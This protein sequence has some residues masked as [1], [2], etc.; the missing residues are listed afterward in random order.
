[1]EQPAGS[2]LAE[3]HFEPL[4]ALLQAYKA[5]LKPL[6]MLEERW[7]K[8][9]DP[10]VEARQLEIYQRLIEAAQ[11]LDQ[12]IKQTSSL[13]TEPQRE[14]TET[15]KETHIKEGKKEENLGN[16]NQES[17]EEGSLSRGIEIQDIMEPKLI[18]NTS[19][20]EVDENWGNKL[21]EAVKTTHGEQGSETTKPP[22]EEID[23]DQ[24]TLEL[25]IRS[26]YGGDESKTSLESKAKTLKTLPSYLGEYEAKSEVR[27]LP[28][29]QMPS[30]KDLD[31]TNL[32]ALM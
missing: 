27:K 30:P 25:E 28:T 1:M 18:S 15:R 23:F 16:K 14:T 3:K 8:Y 17:R 2:V 11:A 20:P 26:E 13:H 22:I 21:W 32:S 7:R 29:L 10:A 12:Q 4:D 24:K 6:E 9:P 31:I 5:R 19:I